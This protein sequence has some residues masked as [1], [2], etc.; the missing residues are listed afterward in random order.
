V[1]L[2]VLLLIG[3][4]GAGISAYGLHR[5]G[6]AARIGALVGVVA[7][8]GVT[9]AAFLLRPGRL[10]DSGEPLRGIFDAH[11]VATAYLRL[12]VGLWGLESLILVLAGWLLGGLV[13]LR[14]LLPATLAAMTGGTVALASADLGVGFAAGAATGLA[15]LV[16]SLHAEGP[17][18]V[19]AAAR[20][21]RVSLVGGALLLACLAIV[22]VAGGLAVF[23]ANGSGAGATQASI[24]VPAMG[25]VAV[26]TT[27]AV[28]A[29]WGLLPFHVR[30]SR[31]ADLVPPE[32]LP[33]LLAWLAV[34]LTVVAIAMMDRLV[35]PLALPL[36]AERWLLVGVALVSMVGA[37]LG[38][39]VHDDLRHAVGYVVIA[40]AGVLVLA[41]AAFDPAAWGAGRSWVVV[42][43]ASK[44][45][46]LAWAAVTEERFGTRSLPD[47][48]GWL[49]RS[50]FLAVALVLTTL[51]TVGLPGWIAFQ[52]RTVLATL[53]AGSPWDALIVVA[54]LLTVPVYV[55]FLVLGAGQPTSRVD[56]AAPEWVAPPG[57]TWSLP[58]FG[59]RRATA[60]EQLP[61]LL[62]GQEEVSFD[63]VP[64]R[65][66]T[67]TSLGTRVRV[68]GQRFV[69]G[70]R[71]DRVQLLSAAVLTLAI[72]AVLTSW[73]ALDLGT[74][75]AEPA[76]ILT[77][78]GTD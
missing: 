54:G 67:R 43:A 16:I 75:A 11:L 29:R 10:D 77:N 57:R 7:R 20:D 37:A 26:G 18:A 4:I 78:A 48:R 28:G 60:D 45:A 24:G 35:T 62:E 6:R 14:G 44:T 47:L 33:L 21:L 53:S 19:A 25:L 3:G 68:F 1:R 12:I 31:L 30:V 9:V 56:R 61:V 49:R 5:G 69:A 8:V 17:A 41:I 63:P 76:P 2:L 32:T 71:R 51:A 65:P 58:R 59:R 55:R 40:E 13:R 66:A 23:S 50:P 38:A 22:P 73:G 74:A 64:V 27:L 34:P 46:L 39:Y 72:L 70:A 52:S 42:L 36:D 15:A